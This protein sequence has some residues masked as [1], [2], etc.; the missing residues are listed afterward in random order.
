MLIPH[1][2]RDGRSTCFAM[3]AR[4]LAD[5]NRNGDLT[6][7]AFVDARPWLAFDLGQRC[8][9]QKLPPALVAG[10]STEVI[11]IARFHERADIT[12]TKPDGTPDDTGV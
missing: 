3:S 10:R 6:G 8:N 12:Q 7:N 1:F 4:L 9:E 2:G 5:R 11:V